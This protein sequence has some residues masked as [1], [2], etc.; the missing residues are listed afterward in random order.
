[1]G[2]GE[3]SAF[4]KRKRVQHYCPCALVRDV[5]RERCLYLDKLIGVPDMH[6]Q[7]GDAVAACDDVAVGGGAGGG[8][9]LRV[10]RVTG[11][12]VSWR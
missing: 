7:G 6:S 11:L 1:M 2:L 3:R 12:C 5:K 4:N 10:S 9:R 8:A